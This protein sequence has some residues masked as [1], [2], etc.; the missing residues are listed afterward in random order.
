MKIPQF[1]LTRQNALIDPE[2]EAAIRG[3]LRSG[4]F[5][6]GPEGQAFEA[7]CAAALGVG[8]AIGVGSGSDALKLALAGLGIG[9]GDEV[10]TP[11]FS[12]VASATAVLQ[13]GARLSFVD[14]DPRTL[15]L[16]PE[17]L[18]AAVT[19]RTRAIIS[20]H[21]YGLPA[22]MEPIRRVADARG[23][24]VIEDA[25][26][27]FGATLNGRPV[28]SLGT[29]AAF[30][31]YPTK[32]L[33][34]YG[35]AGLIA[36]DDGE[37]AARLRRQRNHGQSQ[38]Y[39]HLELGWSSRL[40]ELQAA[41]LRVKLRHAAA[42]TEARRRVAARYSAGLA[43]CPLTLPVEPSGSR[44]VFHQYTIRTPRRDALIK[45]LAAAGIG[46]ACHYPQPI[47]GQ[48]MFRSLGLDPAAWPA[49]WTASQEVLSLPCFPE[50]TEAEADAVIAAIQSFFEGDAECES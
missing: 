43:G 42:W 50:L 29:A 44:H 16:A 1:D 8:H 41:I 22:A 27:A 7:E 14:V 25:A 6:L 48:P 35:D 24:F 47:P 17:L 39:A 34:A 23:L 3:V 37:L 13:V 12:F 40:D 15:T 9:P 21:L 30:S 10:I 46:T 36:T 45:H 18:A 49:A 38:K 26:Q 11:A 2:I 31:F 32:P 33:G 5:I 4:R 20:V 19:P 28:G